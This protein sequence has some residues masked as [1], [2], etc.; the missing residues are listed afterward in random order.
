MM[1]LYALIVIEAI[2][3]LLYRFGG[4]SKEEGKDKFPMLPAW[5]FQRWIRGGG[6]S[7]LSIVWMFLF[8][9][10]VP[11]YVYP[12]SFGMMW[13]AVSTYYDTVFGYDNFWAHGFG[14]G[15]SYI[16]FAIFTGHWVAFIVRIA[17]ATIFCGVSSMISTDVD[18]EECGRGATTALALTPMVNFLCK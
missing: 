13:G 6:C 9:E 1:A 16:L 5:V 3:A 4:C 7:L 8:T 11:W 18:V 14:I 12:V 17:I 15:F 2:N 10:T